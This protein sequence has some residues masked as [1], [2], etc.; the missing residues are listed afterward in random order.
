MPPEAPNPNREFASV[1][2]DELARHGVADAV[3]APGSRSTPI[4]LALAADAR[5]RVQVRIDE[6][7]ASFLALG[8]ARGSGRPV[9]VLCT[10]GTAAAHFHA[11]ALEADQSCVPLLLLTADR[12]P[13]LRGAGANQTIDQLGIYGSAV[14]WWCDLGVPEDRPE[15]MPYWRSVV[16]RAVAMSLGR[17]GAAAGPV[18]LNLPMREPLVITDDRPGY[19]Y[20]L[21]GRAD[22]APWTAVPVV[23]PPSGSV[24]DAERGVVVAGDGLSMAHADAVVAFA[25]A[26]G[27]P[28]IA[29]P[30]SNA[31][32]GRCALRAADVVLR[33]AS[34][35]D[36]HRPD[37]V[38]V[39][40][41]I[42]VSRM[43]GSWVASMPHLVVDPHGRWVDPSR[44][45]A[46]IAKTL[47]QCDGPPT[48]PSW[49]D[50][51]VTAST[52]A[53]AAIDAEVDAD[54]SALSEPQVA[55]DVAATVPD[56]GALVVAS[57]M[58]IRDLDLTMQP[59]TGLR[60]I[61][62]RGVSGIDGFVSTAVGV[63]L[64]HDGPVVALAG[65]LSFVHD[66]NGLIGSQD[67]DLTIVVLNN[68]GGG[69]FSLL[70][71]AISVPEKTFE[72]LFGTPHNLDLGAVCAAYG[73]HHEL[74]KTRADLTITPAGRLRVL[75]VVT[76][77]ES[78][79]SLHQSLAR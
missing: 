34:F 37:L 71:Q 26:R 45:A 41:R 30:H 3:V 73:V 16:S 66:I 31:R 33:D 57:S 52:A 15:S 21:D 11:A 59:R 1:L 32:H 19:S 35:V 58:P 5:I 74:V 28:L 68:N 76:D 38:V 24:I 51:W 75:E 13:E 60:V 70:P 63:A 40:G 27:W 78:N 54:P 65:D 49:L 23:A 77:R 25:E 9:P 14:R 12:P 36:S 62:N 39:V 50:A 10:S 42:G 7:S 61:A 56:G 72:T 69:I 55:R 18:H 44:T 47:P 8:L 29:E 43:L 2:V 20:P 64:T 53:A 17:L 79:K 46:T 6:R 22:G 4:A 67:V 48:D